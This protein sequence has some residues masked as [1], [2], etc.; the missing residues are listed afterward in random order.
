MP[1]LFGVLAIGRQYI[2]LSL[3][4]REFVGKTRNVLWVFTVYSAKT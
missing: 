1:L 4:A 2:W 3:S